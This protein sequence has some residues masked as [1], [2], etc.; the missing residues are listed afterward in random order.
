MTKP[1]KAKTMKS[2]VG[3]QSGIGPERPVMELMSASTW[4][5]SE[6]DEFWRTAATSKILL[7][8]LQKAMD[9]MSIERFSLQMSAQWLES[10]AANLKEFRANLRGGY[11]EFECRLFAVCT[12]KVNFFMSKQSVDEVDSSDVPLITPLLDVFKVLA[13]NKSDQGAKAKDSLAKLQSWHDRLKNDFTQ[14]DI[15]A[16]LEDF[17]KN[18]TVDWVL[19]QSWVERLQGVALHEDFQSCLTSMT[20]LFFEKLI[21]EAHETFVFER[22]DTAL[23]HCT[24]EVA[25]LIQVFQY[26]DNQAILFH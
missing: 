15:L 10:A 25:K 6:S 17:R 11:L 9:D 16:K 13:E 22:T 21:A 20:S 23:R 4:W 26:S 3:G 19:L 14:K 18:D 5:K 12:E 8:R 1:K 24:L 7:P 2:G